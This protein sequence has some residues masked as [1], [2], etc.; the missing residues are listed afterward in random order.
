MRRRYPAARLFL[1]L[2]LVWG[3]ESPSLG[4]PSGRSIRCRSRGAAADSLIDSVQVS[5]SQDDGTIIGSGAAHFLP[6]QHGSGPGHGEPLDSDRGCPGKDRPPG[7]CQIV[8]TR[9]PASP[10]AAVSPATYRGFPGG[11]GLAFGFLRSSPRS[12]RD[13]V[14][15]GIPTRY[16]LSA[17]RCAISRPTIPGNTNS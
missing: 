11:L 10:F 16:I 13:G 9:R 8:F 3:A 12:A 4:S 2:C 17:A 15:G 5:V 14:N 7:Q 1:S 6:G